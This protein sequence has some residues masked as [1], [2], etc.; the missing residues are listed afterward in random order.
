MGKQEPVYLC[1]FNLEVLKLNFRIA[2]TTQSSGPPGQVLVQASLRALGLSPLLTQLGCNWR[3][4][5]W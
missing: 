2:V 4:A 3:P 5:L 1:S